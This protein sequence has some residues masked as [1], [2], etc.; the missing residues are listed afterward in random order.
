MAWI[1]YLFYNPIIMHVFFFGLE[2]RKK[3]VSS[4]LVKR[5]DQ[6]MRRPPNFLLKIVPPLESGLAQW[7]VSPNISA[8]QWHHESV[9]VGQFS[10][11]LLKLERCSKMYKKRQ[12]H[13]HPLNLISNVR[14]NIFLKNLSLN[15][16]FALGPKFLETSVSCHKVKQLQRH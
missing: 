1:I 2:N 14:Q 11:F 12:R 8:D 9:G 13:K 4:I 15:L 10:S 7:I 5:L 6:G 3:F 16:H